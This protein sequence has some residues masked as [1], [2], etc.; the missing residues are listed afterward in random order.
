MSLL[1]RK[2]NLWVIAKVPELCLLMQGQKRRR[3]PNTLPTFGFQG[4]LQSC[5]IHDLH[6]QELRESILFCRGVHQGTF[7]IIGFIT[8]CGEQSFPIFLLGWTIVNGIYTMR[9]IRIWLHYFFVFLF[10]TESAQLSKTGIP[11]YRLRVCHIVIWPAHT[12][13]HFTEMTLYLMN[14][15]TALVHLTEIR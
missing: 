5:L 8:R 3:A 6:I 15:H 9:Y 7:F 1:L 11:V 10:F 4:L 2:P 13:I 12:L 14:R